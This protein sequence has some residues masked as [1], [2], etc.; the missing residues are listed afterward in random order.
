[1][2]DVI[3]CFSPMLIHPAG[4]LTRT[5]TAIILIAYIAG[6]FFVLKKRVMKKVCGATHGSFLNSPLVTNPSV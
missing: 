1:M 4:N 2:N 5:F 6:A 3:G